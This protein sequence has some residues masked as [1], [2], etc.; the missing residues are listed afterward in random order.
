MAA[1]RSLLAIV[2]LALG[3]VRRPSWTSEYVVGTLGAACEERDELSTIYLKE[4]IVFFL[5]S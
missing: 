2:S 3:L 5:P 1:K 4:P